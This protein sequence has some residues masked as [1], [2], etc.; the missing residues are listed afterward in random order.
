MLLLHAAKG[1]K[2]SV[3]M[4]WE[5]HLK[6]NRGICKT[7]TSQR[8]AMMELGARCCTVR[9]RLI[10]STLN[11]EGTSRES[12]MALRNQVLVRARSVL[13]THETKV[14]EGSR[15]QAVWNLWPIRTV[16]LNDRRTLGRVQRLLCWISWA[17]CTWVISF[18]RSWALPETLSLSSRHWE[19]WNP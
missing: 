9:S 1:M 5:S 13:E 8:R 16:W 2:R 18:P 4:T 15:T 17:S 6:L 12:T 7:W 14:Y 3:I 19:G 10:L 11:R